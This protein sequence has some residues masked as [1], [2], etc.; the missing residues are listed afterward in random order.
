MANT[1]EKLWTELKTDAVA[2]W[3]NVESAIVDE[4]H[5]VEPVIEADVVLVLSQFKQLAISTAINL[6]KAEFAALTGQEKQGN[7]ITT[8]E[9]AAEAA[10]KNLA[11][12]DV[13]MFGQ[14]VFN[15]VATT[16]PPK[17]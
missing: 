2:E 11:Y 5:K 10:G 17:P 6:G 3:H 7:L 8:I 9:Q 16:V 12:A 1:F 14:Q 13:Q 15:A 4:W